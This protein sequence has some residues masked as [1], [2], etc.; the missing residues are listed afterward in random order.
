VENLFKQTSSP[1]AKY[2]EYEFKSKDN[3][4]YITPAL[5]AKPSVFD[6]LKNAETMVV[7][8]LNV[9]RLAMKDGGNH[10]PKREILEFAAKYGLLGIMTALPTTP[11][12]M[13][14][15]AV[16]LPHNH[17]I[18]EET[19]ST[20]EYLSIFFPF[21]MPDLYK[22]KTQAHW[23]IHGSNEMKA[24]ALTFANDPMAMNMSFQREYAERVDWLATQLRDLAFTFV[25]NYLYYE[26][27]DRI[28]E[29]TRD[30][31]RR[32][33]S[34]FGGIAPTYHIVLADRPTIVWEFYSLL[35][36]IQM[37]F[38]FALADENRQLRHCKECMK[39]FMSDNPKAKNCENCK[40]KQDAD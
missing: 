40:K 7:D 39:V 11:D 37:M 2:S 31:Y 1:W 15:E 5:D 16:Y 6:P 38:S 21:E 27:Y 17:F 29:M 10:I 25:S 8:A 30:I 3:I 22:D 4:L 34:A 24:L 35:R 33:I 28:D 20:H 13:D 12:F 19:M 23:N 9:G 36:G 14:Y 26:D 32:G 18:R